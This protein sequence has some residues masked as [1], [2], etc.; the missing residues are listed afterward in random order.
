MSY[1]NQFQ[2]SQCEQ[3]NHTPLTL[4]KTL[5]TKLVSR[6]TF[7][8]TPH[9]DIDVGVRK[10]SLSRSVLR[11]IEGRKKT[12]HLRKQRPPPAGVC[13]QNVGLNVPSTRTQHSLAK[14]R[15]D[16]A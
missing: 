15:K 14:K 2:G 11:K 10:L 16:P 5:R 6:Q 9:F 12:K 13:V 1:T 3:K 4:D 7:P 8:T